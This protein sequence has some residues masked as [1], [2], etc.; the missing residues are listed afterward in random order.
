MKRFTAI[1]LLVLL[2]LLATIGTALAAE[3]TTVFRTGLSGEPAGS[4]SDAHGNAVFKF[5]DDSSQMKYK[6]VVNGL[7]NVTMAHIHVAAEP[8]GDGPPVLWLYPDAPPP[9]QIEGTFNGLLGSRTVTS[10]ELTGAAGITSLTELRAAIEQ[11]R[12]YVNVHTTAFPPGE[13]RGTIH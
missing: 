1:T 6:L 12:A 11:G 4:G 7:D 13:I 9:S 8:G 10:A 5:K 3:S 2:T